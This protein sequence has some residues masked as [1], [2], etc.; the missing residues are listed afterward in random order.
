MNNIKEY[1]L[2]LCDS[3]YQIL[4]AVNIIKMQKAKD[5]TLICVIN[6]FTGCNNILY[7]LKK[8]GFN[9]FEFKLK[10]LNKTLKI[11]KYLLNCCQLKKITK[12]K[13][14]KIF[15]SSQNGYTILFYFF[16]Y[17]RKYELV[18]FDEGLYSY[19]C[20]FPTEN[21]FEEY[22]ENHILFKYIFN[23]KHFI[24]NKKIYLYAP[25]LA[26]NDSSTNFYKIEMS[27]SMCKNFL[28]NKPDEIIVQSKIIIFDQ[29]FLTNS[30]EYKKYLKL[31]HYIY[32]NSK[33]KI[34][35]KKHPRNEYIS[36]ELNEIK[37]VPDDNN[38]WEAEAVEI[39]ITDKI[40]ITYYSSAVFMPSILNNYSYTIILLYKLILK[41]NIQLYKIIDN[42][43]IRFQNYSKNVKI[44]VPSTV[45]ELIQIIKRC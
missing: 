25:E 18:F 44:F 33:H 32:I 7:K 15:V 23:K 29:Y 31:L 5:R 40:L 27:Y 4:S 19:I 22:F 11:I 43:V 10:K 38:L 6:M 28:I 13:I 35:I 45:S 36:Y 12:N 34:C 3:P 21:P 39:G 30:I 42:F 41:S 24:F 8:H 26:I 37:I 1:N 14:L 2:F 17:R 16:L 9:I 20:F